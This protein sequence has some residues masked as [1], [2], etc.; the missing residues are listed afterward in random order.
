MI[1]PSAES[2]AALFPAK[3]PPPIDV[4]AI[5]EYLQSTYWWAYLHPNAIRL[6]DRKWLVN[7]ILWGSFSRLRDWAL[8]ELGATIDRDVLQIACVYGN[9][10]QRMAAR[11]GEYGKLDIVDV[12]P[13]QLANLRGKL[14][15]D[16]RIH[17]HHQ[18]SSALHFP[19]ASFD[20]TLLFF[21]L[22]EQ[23]AS[24]RRATLS[25]AM[26]VTRPGGKIVIVDYHQPKPGNPLRYV[27]QAVLRTLE[28]FALDLWQQEIAAYL[29]S[30]AAGSSLV[31]T[32]CFGKLY[33]KIVIT[34]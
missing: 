17:L 11:L 27:M 7:L 8:D 32:T 20:S 30:G 5:P 28:P 1:K 2:I 24:V 10:T 3:N 16:P 6:F 19:A 18:D 33:Q 9:F 22:H 31:K 14:Q 25:E 15:A 12:A 4:P 21:L 23:P 13:I 26:R 34:V 29:P